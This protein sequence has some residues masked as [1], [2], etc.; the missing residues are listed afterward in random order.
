[1]V[2]LLYMKEY[3]LRNNILGFYN[4][5]FSQW[6]GGFKNQDSGHL[7]IDNID[8]MD[9]FKKIPSFSHQEFLFNFEKQDDDSF[10]VFN[11]AEAAMMFGKAI[12]FGDW[13]TAKKIL[14]TSHPSDQKQLGRMVKGY[15]QIIWDKVKFHVVTMINF[16]KFTQNKDLGDYLKSTGH[17]LI[18]EQS[19]H[20]PIWGIGLF[21]E[22]PDAW[23]VS[24]WNGENLLGRA[25]MRVRENL[26]NP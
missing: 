25:I 8:W 22:N 4:G 16:K 7:R 20:D 1:M 18:V 10:I 26:R 3:E 21:R 14:I 5:I 9:T 12:L 17:A 13:E 19:G 15:D 24:K 23:D 6:Y 11:C 2:L